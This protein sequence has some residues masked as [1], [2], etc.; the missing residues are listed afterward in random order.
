MLNRTPY[1]RLLH[2]LLCIL[3]LCSFQLWAYQYPDYLNDAQIDLLKRHSVIKMCVDPNWMPYER[4]NAHNQHEGLASDYLKLLAEKGQFQLVIVPTTSW[5]QTLE[6]AKE[7][8][9]DIISMARDT[10]ERRTY[11]TFTQPYFTYPFSVAT[12]IDKPFASSFSAIEHHRFAVVENYAVNGYL[13]KAYPNLQIIH[14]DNVEEGLERVRDGQAYGYIDSNLAIGYAIQQSGSLDLKVSAQLDYSSSPSIAVRSDKPMLAEI[15]NLILQNVTAKERQAIHNDWVSVRFD[16]KVDIKT[17][18]QVSIV[19]ILLIGIVLFA[20]RR[21]QMANA[22]T[23]RALSQLQQ[24]QLELEDKNHQLEQLAKVDML[25]GLYN[26][27]KIEE[28]LDTEFSRSQRYGSML[29]VILL[30]IDDF[31]AVNDTFGHQTGDQVLRSLAKILK[32]NTRKN[33]MVGRWGGEEFIILCPETD[34]TGAGLL[35]N[36]LLNAIAT[37]TFDG[38]GTKTA[39]FGV[40]SFQEHDDKTQLIAKADRALYKAKAMGKNRV[41]VSD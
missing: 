33:D 2:C 19:A 15:L 37:Y 7:R 29:S 14:V 5:G 35:A 38:V 26:R 39:S 20:N 21:L 28:S 41:E 31:K 36:T 13:E 16:T 4:L 22:K 10:P 17:L 23:Q 1:Q 24:A 40:S 32:S 11:L 3:S 25:T 8:R 27:H 30:D 34:L 6:Y 12:L 9:C 18:I